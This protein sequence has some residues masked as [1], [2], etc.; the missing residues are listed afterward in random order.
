MGGEETRNACQYGSA[1][2]PPMSFSVWQDVSN[3]QKLPKIRVLPLLASFCS[4][5]AKTLSGAN[6]VIHC[7]VEEESLQIFIWV[8]LEFGAA[9]ALSVPPKKWPPFS[10]VERNIHAVNCS[11][12]MEV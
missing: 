5:A 2:L 10:A 11:M 6:L 3:E 1:R 12:F 9:R 7:G 4:G 8:P